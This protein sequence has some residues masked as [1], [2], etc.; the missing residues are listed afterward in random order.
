MGTGM[1]KYG[2]RFLKEERG[3]TAIE[4]AMMASLIAAVVA[5]TVSMIGGQ[6]IPL[7]TSAVAIFP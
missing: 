6:L 7:Y 2:Y 1:N 4:Y 3:A 5:A